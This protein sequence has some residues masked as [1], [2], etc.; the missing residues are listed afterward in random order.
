MSLKIVE[1]TLAAD[2]AGGGTFA[3]A[4]P[5]GTSKGNFS[6]SLKHKLATASGNVF[7]SPAYFTLTFGA[8]TV[9]VNWTSGSPTLPT[10]TKVFLQLDMPGHN[11]ASNKSP[12]T[13]MPALMSRSGLFSI[14][15]GSPLAADDNGYCASQSVAEDAS[16]VLDGALVVS[17]VGVADV[18]R[19]IVAAWTTS[20]TLTFTFRDEHNNLVVEQSAAGTSHTGSKACKRLI[21]VSSDT[22]ITGLTVGTGNKLGM[23]VFVPNH[24][25]I[26]AELM[27]G[28]DIKPPRVVYIPWEI[29]QTELLAATAEQIVC[30][31]D[32]YVARARGIVQGAVTTGGAITFKVGTTDITGLTFTIADADAAGVRYNDAPTTPRSSTTV[33]AAG[34]RLQVVPAAAIDTAGQLNGILEIETLGSAGTF[35]G[36]S[37]AKPTA[38]TGDVRG[39][40]TPPTVPDGST[41]YELIVRL[42]DPDFYGQDQYAG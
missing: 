13:P 29:E 11:A 27:D 18:P 25:S 37:T 39:T 14:N 6:G 34:D 41:S 16:A 17:G 15:F 32:G 1:Y 30:P 5:A 4:Y 21:S 10:G 3:V 23:P 7:G 28:Y 40:Y 33:V 19:N 9:T 26:V 24:R 36:G 8:T 42:D 12:I 31:V 38:L 2:L 20:A 22:A 35:V